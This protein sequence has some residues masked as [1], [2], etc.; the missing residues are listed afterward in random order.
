MAGGL[1]VLFLATMPPLSNNAPP[2]F[3]TQFRPKAEKLYKGGAHEIRYFA[4]EGGEKF[5]FFLTT[6]R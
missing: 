2:C 5:G 4:A 3:A 6:K 1:S